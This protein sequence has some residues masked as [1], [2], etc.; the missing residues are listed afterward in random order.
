M[1][2]ETVFIATIH[3]WS[4]KSEFDRGFFGINAPETF[5]D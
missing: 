5:I 4:G 2:L 3:L 1:R